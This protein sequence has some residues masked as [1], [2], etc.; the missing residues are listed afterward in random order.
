MLTRRGF[1]GLLAGALANEAARKIY[2]LPPAGGW[3]C[4]G[5]MI[6]PGEALFYLPSDGW[7]YRYVYRNIVTG[8]IS[9]ATPHIKQMIHTFSF[10]ESDVIDIYRAQGNGDFEYSQ[11][12]MGIWGV[13]G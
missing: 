6:Y 5:G 11:T 13:K 2:V 7:S 10:P 8:H 9:D 12:A 4:R 3:N 1:F